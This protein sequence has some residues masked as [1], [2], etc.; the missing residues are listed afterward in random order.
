MAGKSWFEG[1]DTGLGMRPASWQ[2]WL[3]TAALF[4]WV[5]VGLGAF[6]RGL[7]HDH[8]PA[9]FALWVAGGAAILLLMRSRTGPIRT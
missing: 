6:A 8:R 4:V 2:G 1:K 5:A 7:P 3:L 9:A